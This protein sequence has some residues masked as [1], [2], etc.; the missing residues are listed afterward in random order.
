[1]IL[2]VACEMSDRCFDAK[3]HYLLLMEH[4]YSN[5]KRFFSTRDNFTVCSIARLQKVVKLP[6]KAFAI[7]IPTNHSDHAVVAC[8][9]PATADYRSATMLMLLVQMFKNHFYDDLRTNQQLGYD[10]SMSAT[11]LDAQ[12]L[13]LCFGIESAKND[14]GQL[15]ASIQR[16]VMKMRQNLTETGQNDE[17]RVR[18]NK[19]VLRNSWHQK[20][21]N[22]ASLKGQF[23]GEIAS[24]EYQFDRINRY[25]VE[26]EKITASALFAFMNDLTDPKQQ[27]LLVLKTAASTAPETAGIFAAFT[28]VVDYQSLKINAEFFSNSKSKIW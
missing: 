14:S 25:L 4:T 6:K 15:F 24:G 7:D 21:I 17:V 26:L 13:L 20:P 16:F 22:R 5:S 1:M 28:K 27:R 3:L 10:V 11:T 23:W 8:Y 12:A 18:S 2:E 19:E 9:Q